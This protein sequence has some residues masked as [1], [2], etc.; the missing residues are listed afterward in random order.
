MN[1]K[2]LL[3]TA[4]AG[5]IAAGMMAPAFADEAAQAGGEKPAKSEKHK[6]KGHKGKKAKNGCAGKK[7]GEQ[8]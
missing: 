8:K 1:A 5:L 6:C 3:T 2:T 7:E 4:V